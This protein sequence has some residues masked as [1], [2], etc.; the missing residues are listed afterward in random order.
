[1][2]L[3]RAQTKAPNI[4]QITDDSLDYIQ[5]IFLKRSELWFNR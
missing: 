5:R 4:Y 3:K 1:M 2:V